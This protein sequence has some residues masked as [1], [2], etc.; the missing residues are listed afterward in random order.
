[1]ALTTVPA[2]LPAQSMGGPNASEGEEFL[3]ALKDGDNN[4][5]LELANKPGGRVVSFRGYNGD[6]PLVVSTR[7]RELSW[8]SFL[9]RR[10]ADPNMGDSKGDTPL[11]IASSLGFDEAAELL[12][13]HKAKVDATNRKGETALTIAVQQR[14]TRIV[15]LLL[16]AGA[17]PD[18]TDHITGYS[19]RDYAKRDTR[20]PQ[21]LKL[22]E[23]TKS[24][25]KTPV[26]G[27]SID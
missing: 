26:A 16:K 21:I 22:I 5:A 18:K 1:M 2:S 27:P 13:R 20:N 7:E 6:T 14:Q 19:P 25:A 3:K 23:S 4:T 9:L 11:I 10:G 17:N 8:I 24:T 15:E 12:L